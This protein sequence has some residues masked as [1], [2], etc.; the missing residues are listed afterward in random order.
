MERL[1]VQPWSPPFHRD[2]HSPSHSQ[3]AAALT[4][5]LDARLSRLSERLKEHGTTLVDM[6]RPRLRE[7]EETAGSEAAD[8]AGFTVLAQKRAAYSDPGVMTD[9]SL[10]TGD[11]AGTVP[12]TQQGDD[13]EGSRAVIEAMSSVHVRLWFYEVGDDLEDVYRVAKQ[14]ETPD[15]PAHVPTRE[16]RRHQR[17]LEMLDE[18]DHF[19]HERTCKTPDPPAREAYLAGLREETARERLR[20]HLTRSLAAEVDQLRTRLLGKESE[21]FSKV[22]RLQSGADLRFAI[23][24][25]MLVITTALAIRAAWWYAP[26]LIAA[27]IALY[28]QGKRRAQQSNDTLIEA[29][30]VDR[31]TSPTLESLDDFIAR[32]R[33]EGPNAPSEAPGRPRTPVQH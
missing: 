15:L 32:L 3:G 13:S 26:I 18:A 28:T 29:L 16:R 22:D 2:F 30:R 1:V 7:R 19:Q 23:A 24:P 12:D 11:V 20:V 5:L 21:L 10:A 27:G 6:A 9:N 31:L 17:Q 4:E 25:P 14:T 8:D 33:P